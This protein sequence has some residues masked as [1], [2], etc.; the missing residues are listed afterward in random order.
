MALAGVAHVVLAALKLESPDLASQRSRVLLC[1][2]LAFKSGALF[3]NILFDI[4]LG[5]IFF[6]G[7]ILRDTDR[8]RAI[9]VSQ[10]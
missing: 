9:T 5:G 6:S 4:S 8:K 10:I 2:H 1:L 7:K 3:S